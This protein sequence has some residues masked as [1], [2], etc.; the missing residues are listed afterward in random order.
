MSAKSTPRQA[1][2]D[3]EE[4]DAP[5][6]ARDL[7][8]AS[9]VGTLATLDAE[10]KAPYASMA[11][12][13]PDFDGAPVLLLSTLA[14]HTANLAADNRVSLLLDARTEDDGSADPMTRPRVSL[15]GTLGATDADIPRE[16]YLRHHPDAKFYSGFK[17]FSF[18]RMEIETGHLVAGFGR[19]V[20]LTPQDMLTAVEGTDELAAAEGGAVE[21]MNKDHADALELY[22]RKLAGLEGDGFVCVACDPDGLTLR[23]DMTLTRILFP[24]RVESPNVLRMMLKQMAED[25]RG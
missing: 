24:R 1:D 22:A 15:T 3:K 7:L 18:Y 19:I 2:N 14:V 10:T 8:R 9:L 12:V 21:H 5:A 16:R 25:A 6:A 4:F 13:A 20:D 11:A 17:D 23:R